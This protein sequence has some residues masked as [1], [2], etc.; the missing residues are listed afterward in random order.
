MDF[1]N[2]AAQ[3]GKNGIVCSSLKQF[4]PEELCV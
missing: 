2:S 3:Q 4:T 1:V